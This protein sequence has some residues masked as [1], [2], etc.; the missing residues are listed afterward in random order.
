[1]EDHQVLA[2]VRFFDIEC[3]HGYFVNWPDISQPGGALWNLELRLSL[4][5]GSYLYPC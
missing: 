2:Y 1:M 4:S 5:I 3:E